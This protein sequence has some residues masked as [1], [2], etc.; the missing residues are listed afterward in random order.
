MCD[1]KLMT[2]FP[3]PFIAVYPP[4][5]NVYVCHQLPRECVC[6]YEEHIPVGNVT[7]HCRKQH[8]ALYLTL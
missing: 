4:C 8:S 5:S 7:Q 1:S 2:F 6:V 3:H